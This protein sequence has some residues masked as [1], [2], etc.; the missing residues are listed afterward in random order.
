MGK[1]E[2]STGVRGY[3]TQKIQNRKIFPRE[4]KKRGSINTESSHAG[5]QQGE[6]G[7]ERTGKDQKA[8]V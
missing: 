5:A 3:E 2:D 7:G 1:G 4:K 6:N 8:N